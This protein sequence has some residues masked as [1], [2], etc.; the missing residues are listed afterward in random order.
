MGLYFVILGLLPVLLGVN[1]VLLDGIE[2]LYYS[3][4]I[5]LNFVLVY[6]IC[7]QSGVT[8]FVQS[9]VYLGFS[10]TVYTFFF[11]FQTARTSELLWREST[12]IGY[13]VFYYLSCTF[14]LLNNYILITSEISTFNNLNLGAKNSA[15]IQNFVDRLLPKHVSSAH[16]R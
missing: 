9:C 11:I 4:I 12:I 10:A 8:S 2:N 7:I 5:A 13:L 16:C 3:H 14:I 1:L 15:K 6:L